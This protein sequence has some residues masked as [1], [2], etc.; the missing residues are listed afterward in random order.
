MK[1]SI[2]VF[3]AAFVLLLCSCSNN[4]KTSSSANIEE[5]SARAENIINETVNENI[6]Q[7]DFVKEDL[8]EKFG[9]NEIYIVKTYM[10]SPS[11]KAAEY[12]ES[13]KIFTQVKHYQLSDGTWKT[14]NFNYKYKLVLTGR[15]NNAVKDSTYE[16]LSNSADITFDMAWKA[17]GLSS[18]TDD[19]FKEEDAIIVAIG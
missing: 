10:E 4:E 19:Y 12:F 7:P 11:D 1:K 9:T 16:V 18:K 2:I 14:D 6:V 3:I 5:D 17:S 15:L 8:D 13:G